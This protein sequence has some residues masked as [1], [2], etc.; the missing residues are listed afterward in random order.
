MCL[1]KHIVYLYLFDIQ[2][3]VCRVLICFQAHSL[4]LLLRNTVAHSN[5]AYIIRPYSCWPRTRPSWSLTTTM[6]PTTRVSP[7]TKWWDS[8]IVYPLHCSN[9]IALSGSPKGEIT[10]NDEN[11]EYYKV[12]L[13]RNKLCV[14]TTSSASRNMTVFQIVC[15]LIG[16]LFV[17]ICHLLSSVTLSR[18]WEEGDNYDHSRESHLLENLDGADCEKFVTESADYGPI[19]AIQNG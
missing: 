2:L 8:T 14:R 5:L 19:R 9:D 18:R 15:Q 6:S 10:T 13:P 16:T 1:T 4:P 11:R 7:S 17:V 3:V 12:C